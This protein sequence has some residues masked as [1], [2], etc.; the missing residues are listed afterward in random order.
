MISISANSEANKLERNCF[1]KWAILCLQN[2]LIPFLFLLFLLPDT[3]SAQMMDSIRISF[4]QK[5]QFVI[6]FDSRNS[7]IGDNQ[8]DILGA[9]LGIEFGNKFS[10][11][12]SAHLM[13]E[14]DSHFYKNY[15]VLSPDNTP[16]TVQAHLQLFYI[17]YYAEYVF[18]SSEYWKFSV[19]LQLGFGES[20]YKY[21]YN[22]L[23]K[24][25]GRHLI[26][27]YEPIIAGEYKLIKWLSLTGEIGYRFLLIKNPAVP[28][29]F[30]SPTFSIGISIAYME[31]YKLLVRH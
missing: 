4:H 25:S 8:A 18:H 17:A 29:N 13:N 16:V 5:A 28:E 23:D 31:L 30:N 14:G 6:A 1:H 15:T 3:S 20:N 27:T 7:F 21:S 12:L 9:K 10:V 22:F 2:Q 26:V 19:P 11:G 24:V